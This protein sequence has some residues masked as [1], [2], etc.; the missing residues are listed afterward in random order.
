M[1]GVMVSQVALHG[2]PGA[3][4]Q[5]SALLWHISAGGGILVAAVSAYVTREWSSMTVSRN[6]VSTSPGCRGHCVGC[7][8]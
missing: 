6:A 4:Y 7:P 2:D 5:A 1:G 3:V 8:R